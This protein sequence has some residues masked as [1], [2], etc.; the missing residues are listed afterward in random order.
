MLKLFY[1]ALLVSGLL[2][3]Q[4]KK[5]GYTEYDLDN[6]LH[7]ILNPNNSLPITSVTVTYHVGSKN[8]NPDRTGFAHF[9]EHLMFEGTKNIPTG[10]YIQFVQNAGGE[11]NAYTFFDQ[12]VYYETLPSNQLELG[13]WLESERML[14][15]NIDSVGVEK[16]RSIVKEERKERCDNT[17]Y[18]S[19]ME[20]IFKHSFTQNPYR[21]TT[22]GSFQYI[23]QA[24]VSEFKDFYKTYYVPDNAVLS[25]SGDIDIKETKKLIEKYFGDIPKGNIKINRPVFVNDE[26]QKEIIDTVYD[27][28]QLPGV[29]ISYRIPSKTDKDFYAFDLLARYMFSGKSSSVYKEIVDKQ[30]KAY[31]LSAQPIYL[32]QQGL[33][34]LFAIVNQGIGVNT[35]ENAIN[36]EIEKIK[37]K[38][39]SQ[40]DLDKQLNQLETELVKRNMLNQDAAINLADNYIFFKDTDMINKEFEKYQ[41]VTVADLKNAAQKYFNKN[42]RVVIFYLPNTKPE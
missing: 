12:T 8:E 32:E 7:V 36:D 24:K 1:V 25:V 17:P 37:T 33:A 4:I 29:V 13:L 2:Q 23:D 21:W 6:G 40:A 27:K 38:D 10:K 30:S 5:F 3:A 19:V 39:F 9:F 41:S 28:I 14:H 11:V 22:I 35:L 34:V 16:Q 42:K 20:E 18:G 15:L 26:P 31:M